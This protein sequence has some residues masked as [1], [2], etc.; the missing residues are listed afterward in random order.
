MPEWGEKHHPDPKWDGRNWNSF[1]RTVAGAS[2]V[3][4]ILTAR[5]MGLESAWNWPAAF[6]YYDRYWSKEH[7]KAGGGSN[8]ISRFV[9]SMWKAYRN[10]DPSEF[11]DDN[12]ATEVW[13]NTALAPQTGAFTLAFDIVPSAG[14]IEGVTGLSSNVVD[15]HSD[16]AAGVRFAPS[17]YIDAPMGYEYNAATPLRY[18]PG[19]KYRVVMS[20]DVT[21]RRYSVNVTPAGGSRVVIANNWA[22][23]TQKTAPSVLSNFGFSSSGGFHAILDLALHPS[24]TPASYRLPTKVALDKTSSKQ[25]QNVALPSVN[26][27]ARFT[28]DMVAESTPIDVVTGI[29]S[30]P[31]QHYGDFAIAIRLGRNGLFNALNGTTWSKAADVRYVAGQVYQIS[32]H[33]DVPAQR[34][35]ATITP[36]GGEPVT[37]ARNWKFRSTLTVKQLNNLTLFATLGRH[38]VSQATLQIL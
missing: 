26:G 30:G 28:F 8:T 6:D 31:A 38:K 9:A 19:V 37:I 21:K 33:I 35:S 29:T 1:Y 11:T 24:T 32:I 10:A 22:F 27:E 23:R 20:V 25:W 4:H 17:G 3:G 18:R 12:I 15:S 16:I 13:Q 36:K 5:L 14:N 2:T 7:S 34:Y